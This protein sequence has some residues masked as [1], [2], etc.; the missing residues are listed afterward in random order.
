MAPRRPVL[1]SL[2]V[3]VFVLNAIWSYVATVLWAMPETGRQWAGFVGSIVG[4][5]LECIA[6]AY[7]FLAMRKWASFIVGVEIAVFGWTLWAAGFPLN[8]A[9][10]F[11]TALFFSMV[12]A[13]ILY[14]RRMVWVLP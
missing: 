10:V 2:L 14:W 7:A 4:G 1:I 3:V 6:L 9:T 8:A 13:L 12:L 11:A 5:G